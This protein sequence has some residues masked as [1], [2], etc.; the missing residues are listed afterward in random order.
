MVSGTEVARQAQEEADRILAD[1]VDFQDGRPRDDIAV[2]TL[3]V[4]TDATA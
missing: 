4:P 1:V 2:L 3:R